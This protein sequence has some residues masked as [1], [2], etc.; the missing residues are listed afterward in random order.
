MTQSGIDQAMDY[1]F[2][3]SRNTQAV[4]VIR[5][6]VIVGEQYAEGKDIGQ[7]CLPVGQP[8]NPL[9]AH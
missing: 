9:L 6:G 2:D 1:A 4:L 3:A 8:E 7:P 5:H